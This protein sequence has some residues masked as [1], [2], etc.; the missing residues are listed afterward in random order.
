MDYV[1]LITNEHRHKPKFEALVKAV[2]DTFGANYDLLQGMP[3]AF[4]LDTA[5]GAQ[6]DIV[7]LWVGQPRLIP[8]V[9]LVEF[10]GFNGLGTPLAYGE[11]GSPALGGRFYGEGESYTATSVL[12]DPEYR[13]LLRAKIVRN[14]AKGVT[15]EF[16]KSFKFIF[17]APGLISDPGIMAIGIAIGRDLSLVE[18]AIITGLDIL[19]RPAGVRIAWRGHYDATAYF[20]FDGQL[21]AV[22]F[23]EEG[24]TALYGPFMEEF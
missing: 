3:N 16:A 5:I 8:N 22:G 21:N 19:P 2:S 20:G 14:H 12:A 17:N 15:L 6:L 10:F 4:N 24:S 23:S 18:K 13:F 1:S 11:E 7:G 9:L